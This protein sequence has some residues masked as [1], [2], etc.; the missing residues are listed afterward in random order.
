[1]VLDHEPWPVSPAGEEEM[2]NVDEWA[3]IRR[4]HFAEKMGIKGDRST[5]RRRPQHGAQ[6]GALERPASL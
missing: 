5:P 2:I 3:E 6:R 4:L 1:M